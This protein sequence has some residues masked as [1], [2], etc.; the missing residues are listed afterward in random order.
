MLAICFK[1]GSNQMYSLLSEF[2]SRFSVLNAAQ[3]SSELLNNMKNPPLAYLVVFYTL[4]KNLAC[5]GFLGGVWGNYSDTTR[6]LRQVLFLVLKVLSPQIMPVN[7]RL[8]HC[9]C[10]LGK[11]CL[12]NLATAGALSSLKPRVCPSVLVLK[13]LQ[14]AE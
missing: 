14:R 8:W 7:P 2:L 1:C 12:V 10:C 5:E 4:P 6:V 11:S 3:L 13:S 9:D